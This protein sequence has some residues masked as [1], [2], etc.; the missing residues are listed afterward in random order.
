LLDP[1]SASYPWY[2]PGVRNADR[3]GLTLIETVFTLTL[4]A[5]LATIS[6]RALA[7]AK[8]KL[9]TRGLAMAVAEE[10]ESA[11]QLAISG[12]HPVALGI[13]TDGGGNPRASSIYRLEGWNKPIVTS[14]RGYS[15]DYPNVVFLAARWSGPAFSDGLAAS[16]LSKFSIFDLDQWLPDEFQNDFIFCFTPDGGL[17][18]NNQPALNGRYTVVVADN[19]SVSGS[20]PNQWAITGADTAI[21]L[22]VS[23]SGGVDL[24]TGM[25][26]GPT[27]SGGSGGNQ[28]SAPQARTEFG[29]GGATVTITKVRVL[30]NP[31]DTPPDQGICVPGQVVTLEV[32]A[33]D[34]AG[35]ALFSKWTQTAV[36][37]P[38]VLG[39]FSYPYSDVN[40][41][42]V[43]E[44]DKMEFVYD[45]PADL[46][47]QGATPPT[48]VGAFR[49]RWNWTVPISSQPG[50]RYTVQADV[51]DV[52]G[53]V[54]I[55]NPPSETFTTPPNGRLLV[56]R[57][58]PD[59]LWELVIMNPDGSGERVL[60]AP[61]VEE[62]M[63]SLDRA[64]SKMAFLQGT[65]PNRF[66]KVRNLNGGP[67]LIL[68]GPG[69]FNS[70]SM[71]PDGGWVSYR[72]DTTSQLITKRLDGSDTF[73]IAQNWSGSGHP[74]KKSRSG[75]SQN[76]QFMLYE[77]DG[78]VHSMN[79]YGGGATTPLISGAFWNTTGTY[80]GAESPYAP[81]TFM[82]A[83]GE[84]VVLSLG[85]N[86][87][88]LVNFPVTQANYESGGIDPGNLALDYVVAPTGDKLRV[89][90]GG[91]GPAGSDVDYPSISSDGQFLIFTRSPQTS[92]MDI[93]V[94]PNEDEDGQQ[95]VI[96]P[97]NGNPDNFIA[98]PGGP[99][100][101]SEPDVR[102]A[103]WIPAEQ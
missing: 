62:C 91:N 77:A 42:L 41:N 32:Y 95:L 2:T 38:G 51:R 66:V 68:G 3:R 82:G 20:A 71:S 45:L 89:G 99:T 1:V 81:I 36:D 18:T 26:G 84:R 24:V 96:V 83:S 65:S 22:L 86:N 60:S 97:R 28:S 74:I 39:Q 7:P 8:Q 52:K 29:A 78:L 85:N 70:V 30:P 58:G 50:D 92:G 54:Y 69:T 55:E 79:L 11:R 98:G 57:L 100:V 35:R 17:I 23:P 67:E 9:P 102:R 59:G 43:G 75:W 14:S 72:N 90:Y 88:V 94:P 16:P 19:P 15:G 63:P 31:A 53:E 46:E 34:P 25:P 12:G 61:G 87:P 101:M 76:S 64:S 49:A 103:V 4:V 21:T 47:W 33:Y 13:P 10:F 37:T 44:V 48:G 56:E 73:T 40:S 27:T 6:L 93:P 5:I 80:D